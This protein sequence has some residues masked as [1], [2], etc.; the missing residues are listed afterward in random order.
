VPGQGNN[1][2]NG[3]RNIG[4]GGGG[5]LGG[6]SVDITAGGLGFISNIIP[7]A[8]NSLRYCAGG[9]GSNNFFVQLS[10]FGRGGGAATFSPARTPQDG[11]IIMRFP[12]FR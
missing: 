8:L 10:N 1:G 4:G 11:C 2:R 7:N 9:M 5:G 3:D 6:F 12:S